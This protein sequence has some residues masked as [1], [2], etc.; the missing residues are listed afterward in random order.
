MQLFVTVSYS[1][2]V[3]SA[4]LFILEKEQNIAVKTVL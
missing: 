2:A 3:E 1:I 4:E